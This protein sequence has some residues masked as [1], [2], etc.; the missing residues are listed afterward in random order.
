MIYI[1]AWLVRI[2][3]D[4]TGHTQR[5]EFNRC[6]FCMKFEKNLPNLRGKCCLLRDHFQL[7]KDGHKRNFSNSWF[8][9]PDLEKL[10][11]DQVNPSSTLDIKFLLH[12]YGGGLPSFFSFW[13]IFNHM[14]FSFSEY[15]EYRQTRTFWGEDRWGWASLFNLTKYVGVSFKGVPER[16]ILW[17]RF[18]HIN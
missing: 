17:D 9:L 7:C 8:E 4:H 5:Q 1:Q 6:V 2:L 13:N 11:L 16:F 3:W 10:T 15:G 14:P 12:C 18:A